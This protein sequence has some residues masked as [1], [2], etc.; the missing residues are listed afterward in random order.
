MMDLF[1]KLARGVHAFLKGFQGAAKRDSQVLIY[2]GTT[3]WAML[4]ALIEL[5]M[6]EKTEYPDEHQEVGD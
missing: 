3:T 4:G 2:P 6:E 1:Q 5:S